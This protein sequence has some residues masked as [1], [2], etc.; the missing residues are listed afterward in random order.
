MN[1]HPTPYSL[2]AYS[3]GEKLPDVEAHLPMC[4]E[5]TNY[6]ASIEQECDAIELPPRRQNAAPKMPAL[7]WLR[8]LAATLAAA[9]GLVLVL[10]TLAPQREATTVDETTSIKGASMAVVLERDGV[11][12]RHTGAMIV[13]PGDALRVEFTLER[14][15][16]VAVAFSGDDG[17]WVPLGAPSHLARGTHLSDRAL[18]FDNAPTPGKLM[19]GKPDALERARISHS[20]ES[21]MVLPLRVNP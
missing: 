8:P 3:L 2:D 11:Q 12:S 10:Y 14:E 6:L 16:D 1:R 17:S 19:L 7:L 13:R 9:A 18:R 15:V 5:C 21:L 20:S 4:A